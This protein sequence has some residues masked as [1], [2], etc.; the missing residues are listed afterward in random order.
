MPKVKKTKSRKQ[1]NV[2]PLARL[3]DLVEQYSIAGAAGAVVIL[4]AIGATLWACGY[5]GLLGEQIEA[6]ASRAAVGAGFEIRRVTLSGRSRAG[7]DEVEAALGPAVGQSI[8]HY[9]LDEARARVEQLG[10]VRVAAV[11]RLLPDTINISIRE[12]SPAAVWQMDGALHLIDVEGAV[13]REIGAYEYSQLPLIIGAGA[14]AA[15]SEILSALK[16]LPEIYE[17]TT[18][19]TRLADRRWDLKMRSGAVVKLPEARLNDA[20]TT[21]STLKE[22]YGVLD[23]RLEY[24][25]LRDPERMVV[26]P[27]IQSQ[28]G[29]NENG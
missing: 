9:S 21:L 22:S 12:R 26:R 5:V 29:A 24:I 1:S 17:E 18:A 28:A 2:S 15:A 7:L 8:L 23:R 13:I 16:T 11:T 10:W 14:P 27:A 6:R 3:R 19:A 4:A 20:L 25:D